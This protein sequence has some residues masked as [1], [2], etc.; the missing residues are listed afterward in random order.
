MQA[1]NYI[2]LKHSE[3]VP[4]R[5]MRETR[6]LAYTLLPSLFDFSDR[7]LILH[8]VIVQS[9][10][11]EYR[12]SLSLQ[13][14]YQNM[15]ARSFIARRDVGGTLRGLA[16]TAQLQTRAVITDM[17]LAS[18]ART[19][20]RLGNRLQF[21]GFRSSRNCIPVK[22]RATKA[23]RATMAT[24]LQAQCVE[25]SASVGSVG[26]SIR[27]RPEHT[28]SPGYAYSRVV[29]LTQA[30]LVHAH[31]LVGLSALFQQGARL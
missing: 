2:I 10:V 11:V 1:V 27:T 8:I 23:D 3:L 14:I 25:I 15:L 30:A 7:T 12:A 26:I 19:V 22:S 24:V 28:G 6:E 16:G 18:A 4:P 9:C 29:P 5:R 13:T 21:V 17:S 31:T 20:R